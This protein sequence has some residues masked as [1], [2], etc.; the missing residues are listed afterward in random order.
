MPDDA[1]TDATD[2]T[3]ADA[4]AVDKPDTGTAP[5]ADTTDWKA[6]AAA[7]QADAEKW[8]S[9]SR[10]HEDRAKA[11]ADAA[12]KAKTVEEQLA[13]LQQRL[14]DRDTADT[15]KTVALA[16]EKLA[17]KLVRA[18]LSDA[19]A[20]VIAGNVDASRLVKDGSPDTKAIN[21]LAAALAKVA[22]RPTPDLDQGR[23]SDSPPPD[24]NTLIRQAAGRAS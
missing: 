6:L 20:T 8:K 23:K 4:K 15:Q 12:S 18:G 16:G 9:Q 13:E 10:K 17:A 19:D 1:L 22:G 7:A 3:G 5:P 11:N 14:S 2:A 24:M 21:E